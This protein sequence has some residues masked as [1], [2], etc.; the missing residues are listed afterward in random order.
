M[1]LYLQK[2]SIRYEWSCLSL[3]CTHTSAME[4]YKKAD[5]M[6]IDGRRVVVDYERGR[7]Q[8]SWLPRRLGGGKGDTRRLRESKAVLEAAALEI[9][10]E[11][12]DHRSSSTHRSY[13]HDRERE[14]NGTV[15]SSSRR[16]SRSRDR[17]RDRDRDRERDRDRD[18]RRHDDHRSSRDGRSDGRSDG[19]RDREYRDRDRDR[20]KGRDYDR[21]RH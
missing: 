17:E 9:A 19:D 21:R 10:H 20:D 16:H 11:D 4:A 2:G 7:T 6:K 14:H 1:V 8:K 13:S 18:S 15:S 12:R 5:G 3:E